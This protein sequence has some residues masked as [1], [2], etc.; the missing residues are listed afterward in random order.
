LRY[1]SSGGR[2]RFFSSPH[3]YIS[4]LYYFTKSPLVQGV[5]A[6]ARF[7]RAIVLKSRRKDT[8]MADFFEKLNE[9]EKIEV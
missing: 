9:E 1:H 5:F 8:A 2:G 3:R 4:C 7:P 6:A